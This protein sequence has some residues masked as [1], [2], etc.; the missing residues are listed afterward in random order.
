MG[1]KRK[2]KKKWFR[3]SQK[4]RDSLTHE[5]YEVYGGFPS[6]EEMQAILEERLTTGLSFEEIMKR[7][8]K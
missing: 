2:R 5:I 1:R 7:R 6:W 3:R 4:W 8:R